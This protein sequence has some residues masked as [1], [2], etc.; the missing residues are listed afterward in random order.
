LDYKHMEVAMDIREIRELKNVPE[1]D[2]E[3]LIKDFKSEGAAEVTRELQT[4]G[5]YTIK[6]KF[7]GEER[8]SS[9]QYLEK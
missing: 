8:D 7:R 2:L 3:E 5:K 4:D 9:S 6:A 1:E